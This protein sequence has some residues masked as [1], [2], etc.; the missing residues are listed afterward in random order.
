MVILPGWFL[1]GGS[2]QGPVEISRSH[3]IIK[4]PTFHIWKWTHQMYISNI[5]PLGEACFQDVGSRLVGGTT[6]VNVK[7][8]RY[9]YKM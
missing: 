3:L 5:S 1:T 2:T 8:A 7:V 9:I 6:F 4:E